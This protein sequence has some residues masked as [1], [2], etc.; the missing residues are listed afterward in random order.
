MKVPGRFSAVLVDG[1]HR[2]VS[3]VSF[4]NC[5]ESVNYENT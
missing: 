1:F 4:V 5:Q 2:S 3:T